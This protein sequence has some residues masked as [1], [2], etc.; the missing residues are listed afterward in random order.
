MYDKLQYVDLT[1]R[2]RQG[3]GAVYGES[4]QTVFPLQTHI[5]LSQALKVTQG[6]PSR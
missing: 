6:S 3:L 2:V 5:T 1:P 4:N